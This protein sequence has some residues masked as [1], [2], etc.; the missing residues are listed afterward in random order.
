MHKNPYWLIF[1]LFIGIAVIGYTG[2][3]FYKIYQYNRL[4]QSIAP[5]SIEWTIH[6]LDVD[7]FSLMSTYQFDWN[8]KNYSGSA[9]YS[10]RYLN[11]WAAQ[12]GLG[13]RKLE[14][15]RV[16]FDPEDPH[17]STLYHEYPMKQVI[18]TFMLWGLLLYFAWLG[19][20]VTRYTQ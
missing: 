10:D 11:D 7:S 18:Y 15:W 17:F 8:Q 2:F 20:S 19:H 13:R 14:K 12:E 6:P 3:T 16:W 1:L 5:Q 9:E 4:S